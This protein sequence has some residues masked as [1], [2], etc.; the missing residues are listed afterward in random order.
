M[1]YLA[2]AASRKQFNPWEG[3]LSYLKERT[4]PAAV[5][6]K[7]A[8]WQLYMIKKPDDIGAVFDVEWPASRRPDKD[9]LVVR[10]EISKRLLAAETE[11]YVRELR[12]EVEQIHVRALEAYAQEVRLQAPT[13]DTQKLY[14]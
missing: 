7:L 10:M 5:P 6:R 8:D 2:T 3:L 14:V 1:R 9:K 4:N 12:E 11:D 13:E